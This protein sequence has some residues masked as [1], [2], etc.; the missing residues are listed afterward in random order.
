MRLL[1]FYSKIPTNLAN[2]FFLIIG[3]CLANTPSMAEIV[4]TSVTPANLTVN[5]NTGLTTNITWTLTLNEFNATS[6][7]AEF[8]ILGADGSFEIVNTP[9]TVNAPTNSAP[10]PVSVRETLVITPE[11]A[12][13]VWEINRQELIY[14]RFFRDTQGQLSSA[15]INITLIDNGTTPID[16]P[17]RQTNPL[18]QLRSPSVNLSVNRLML[19][20]TDDS[21]VSFIEQGDR[22]QAELEVS[23]SGSG[24]LRGQ[25]QISDPVSASGEP[26]YRTLMLVNATLTLPQRTTL[27]SPDLPSDLLGRYYLRFCVSALGNQTLTSQSNSECPSELI[28]TTV[29]YQVFPQKKTAALITGLSPNWQVATKITP[30]IWPEIQQVFVNQLQIFSQANNDMAT[31]SEEQFITGMLLPGDQSQTLLSDYVIQ[32]LTPGQ[33]YFWRIASYNKDGKL[34]ARSQLTPFR[35]ID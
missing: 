14:R 18:G 2:R 15:L 16:P 13:F 30:F 26:V 12:Q 25:W 22:L 7:E 4:S 5:I 27:I 11:L 23:Y 31:K 17:T 33:E 9:L 24:V 35:F 8:T 34:I 20:F 32:N 6:T 19:N 1:S 28:S 21:I 29:G 3:L 10:Q